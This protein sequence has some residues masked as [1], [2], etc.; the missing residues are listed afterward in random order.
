LKLDKG[1]LINVLASDL[2]ELLHSNESIVFFAEPY[3]SDSALS[4]AS[5]FLVSLGRSVSKGFF[6]HR[7]TTILVCSRLCLLV[8]AAIFALK[9][10]V[11]VLC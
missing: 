1:R 11:M 5:E 4:Q 8:V 7:Q 6:S 10:I 9:L 2:G 3:N